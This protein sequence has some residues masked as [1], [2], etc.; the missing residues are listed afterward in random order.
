MRALA[1]P[2]GIGLVAAALGT[3]LF[4]LLPLPPNVVASTIPWQVG[5]A[6]GVLVGLGLA[7]KARP[8]LRPLLVL[9]GIAFFVAALVVDGA[10][11]AISQFTV[12]LSEKGGCRSSYYLSGG[13]CVPNALHRA[14]FARWIPALSGLG[15]VTWIA[16]FFVERKRGLRTQTFTAL[17]LGLAL[18]ACTLQNGHYLNASLSFEGDRVRA[19][20]VF[21]YYLGSKYYKELGHQDIYA[22]VLAA[23]DDYQDRV[24]AQG[25]PKEKRRL[26]RSWNRIKEARELRTYKVT[27]R[28]ELVANFDRSKF[29]EER[30]RQL[31][32]DS[33]FL[34]RYMGFGHPGWEDCFK[35]LGFNP[36]P[37]WTVI[38]TPLANLVPTKWPWFWVISNSDVLFY[39]FIIGLIWWA[40]GLR[41]AAV[42]MLWLN[43]AQ[44]N[45]A[46]FTGGFLQ[47]DWLVSCLA[48]IAFYRKGWYRSAGVALSWGAMTRVFPGFLV[49]PIGLKIL[50]SLV[51]K[52]QAPSEP[53]SGP[54][55][56]GLLG[57][58]H[59]SHWNF[60]VAF[61]LACS[62]LFA[63][64]C[65][66]GRGVQNWAEWYEKI[67][68]HS[69]THPITSNMRVGVGRIAVHKPRPLRGKW[70]EIGLLERMTA[71]KNKHRFWSTIR[72]KDKRD[73]VANSQ[74]KK[75][76][77]QLL[78]LPF[79]LLA[80]LR[81]KDI[82][83]M[84][85]MLFGVFLLV[86]VS[87]YYAATWAMLFALGAASAALPPIRR[88]LS[89]PAF[90]MGGTLLGVNTFFYVP[91]HVTTS[92]F[93]LNYLMY[94]AFFAL[95]LG[96][97]VKDARE[98]LERRRTRSD[99]PSA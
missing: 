39:G 50:A 19:W 86:T 22:A 65:I 64:S 42:M 56:R 73:R 75:R 57:R 59:R 29:S 23:D 71:P 36:A 92:Y 97:L 18:G 4:G 14:H 20:N 37:P 43:S 21:H 76:L 16:A 52:G 62:M 48:T 3:F 79:L 89:L 90:F 77:L 53:G 84:I 85:L 51:G 87:R 2:V 93:V 5:G 31:G 96:Y 98:L 40:F 70:E 9:L 25:G 28:G 74:P 60:G 47:Y 45:E 30:L 67:E 81:R 32:R 61:T 95:C 17:L 38:G 91:G 11:L 94:G 41:M 78:A 63:A 8:S 34:K 13:V 33:R 1:A 35:D 72:G 55:S 66:T 6:V 88:R 82:D 83:G 49:L 99:T 15:L 58:V 46:R 26:K 54:L 12:P 27:R 44:L 24:R 10:L 69:A 80:L 7:S 68:N